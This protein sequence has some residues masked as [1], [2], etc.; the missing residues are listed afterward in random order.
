L[1]KGYDDDITYNFSMDLNPQERTSSTTMVRGLSI[2]INTE[3]IDRVTTLPL[4]V[5]WRKE[6]KAKS[7]L[8]KKSFFTKDEKPIEDKNGIRRERLPHS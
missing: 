5:Q 4:G 1:L 8:A 7:T 3:V 6:D 2:T